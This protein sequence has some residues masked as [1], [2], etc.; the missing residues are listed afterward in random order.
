V[1]G[2][3]GFEIAIQRRGTTWKVGVA[4]LG[5]ILYPGVMEKTD[6]AVACATLEV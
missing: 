3:D 1:L 2:P 4:S 6:A 5:R